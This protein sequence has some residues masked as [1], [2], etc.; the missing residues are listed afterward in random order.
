MR[1]SAFWR[2]AKAGL[3]TRFRL[4]RIENSAGDGTPDVHFFDRLTQQGG[5]IELKSIPEYP[6]RATT[7]VFGD[8]GLRP[9]QKAWLREYWELGGNVWILARAESDRYLVPGSMSQTFNEM[10]KAD[11][12]GYRLK[13]WDIELVRWRP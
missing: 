8:K 6:V 3:D 7:R 12:A 5:W 9:E 2:S 4:W 1:A 10:T 13:S 11:L